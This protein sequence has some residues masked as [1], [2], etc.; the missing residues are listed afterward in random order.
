MWTPAIA[1]GI[2][3]I[4]EQHRQLFDCLQ[5]LQEAAEEQ[6]AIYAVYAINRLQAYAREHF[7]EEEGL[8][9]RAG[10][11][12]L[13]PHAAEHQAFRSRLRELANRA[14][15]EDVSVDTVEFLRGWLTHHVS[16][17]DPRYVPWVRPRSA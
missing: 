14:V 5:Q 9:R 4:D 13:G 12:D 3:S 17:V 15:F 1:I 8:M 6:R 7:E 11:P 10:Y 16:E 2:E